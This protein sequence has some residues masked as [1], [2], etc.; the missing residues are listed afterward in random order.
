M[1]AKLPHKGGIH[2]HHQVTEVQ[3]YRSLCGWWRQAVIYAL[4]LTQRTEMYEACMAH[5]SRSL[6]PFILLFPEAVTLGQ[7]GW[8]LQRLEY[9]R[10]KINVLFKLKGKVTQQ[11]QILMNVRQW[12]TGTCLLLQVELNLLLLLSWVSWLLHFLFLSFFVLF[13]QT[14]PCYSTIINHLPTLPFFC[15]LPSPTSSL[16]RGLLSESVLHSLLFWA[17]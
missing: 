7:T 11:F 15:S 9:T 14:L 6:N 16:S 1:C 13:I 5:G 4:G 10:R 8:G 12:E 2:H 17:A 3:G